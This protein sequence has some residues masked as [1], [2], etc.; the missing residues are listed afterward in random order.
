MKASPRAQLK[1]KKQS[2]VQDEILASAARLFAERGFRAVTIDDI[3][4]SLG[5]TKSV[6]YYYF[7][8]KNELL[9]MIFSRI[10]DSYF[11]AVNEVAARG[12]P[13]DQALAEIIRRHAL[14]VMERR[15]WT[16]IYFRE[17]AEL[18]ERQR[19]QIT[20]K[21]RRVRRP[22]RGD[23]RAGREAGHVPQHSRACRG[24]RHPRH[25]ATGSI[26]GTT[27]RARCRPRPSPTTMPRCWPTAIPGSPSTCR[28]LPNS[29]RRPP[30]GQ[31]RRS[32]RITFAAL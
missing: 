29:P 30:P 28:S 1:A 4:S 22:D 14:N 13:P 19:R 23:L 21:K 18:D 15:D 2:H 6:I 10:Y 24:Q 20:K 12:L 27:S 17:E 8:S 25:R 26:S 5:Y 7:K 9:W 16:A 31:R 32:R 3:A 11:E